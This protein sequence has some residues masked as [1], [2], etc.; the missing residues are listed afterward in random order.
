MRTEAVTPTVRGSPTVNTPKN[1]PDIL[2]PLLGRHGNGRSLIH[3]Y[4]TI[5]PLRNHL[6]CKQ[7]S[8]V[9]PRE[10]KTQ[11]DNQSTPEYIFLNGI[12]IPFA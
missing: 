5:I 1:F 3:S 11:S 6:F 10:E 7:A 12:G 8:G 2:L 4:I 9:Q